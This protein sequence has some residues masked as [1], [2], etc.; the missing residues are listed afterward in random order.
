MESAIC[1]IKEKYFN[2]ECISIICTRIFLYRSH[3]RKQ[4]A[5]LLN[6]IGIVQNQEFL[7]DT[8]GCYL[9]NY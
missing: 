3:L 8:I 9:L 7:Y 5:N 1:F 2:K 4:K 6:L